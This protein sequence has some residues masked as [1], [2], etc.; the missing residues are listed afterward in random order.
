MTSERAAPTWRELARAQEGLLSRR[1]L[2]ML[3]VDRHHVRAQ[4]DAERWVARSSMVLSTTTGPP[5][6]AQMRWVGVLHAGPRA[7]VADLSAAEVHGLQRWHRDDT[8]VI[9]PD[10]LVLDSQV[11][12][13][14]YR[15]TRRHLPSMRSAL[16]LPTMKLEPAV[17]HFAA[18]QRSPRTAQGVMA[19]VVQQGLT[20][21]AAL[22]E[23]IRRMK[24]L[25]KAPLLRTCLEEIAGGAGSLAEVDLAR[26][27]RTF[28]LAAP[29]RQARRRGS[30]GRLR[31]TDAEWRLSDGRTL[32][33][34]ID[35]G[36]HMEV[37]H[38]EEDIA[39][40]RS[41]LAA[42]R[43]AV[44]CTARELREDAA[45]LAADLIRLGVPPRVVQ[46]GA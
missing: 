42:D 35:G 16:S 45:R 41:L 14:V 34:E 9:I 19:A 43:Q 33:L 38:W 29:T 11:D 46:R 28:G 21:P 24:P 39:R 18:Y 3:G 37:E 13:V 20:T 32:V 44:R 15:R 4:V 31:Y 26:L 10:D 6:R 17:L 25:H 12:G 27:C 30:D 2:T 36:F 8:T 7:L 1:Q 5:T 22:Q 40:E 23:W